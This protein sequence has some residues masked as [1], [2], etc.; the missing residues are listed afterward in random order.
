MEIKNCFESGLKELTLV[1]GKRGERLLE[2]IFWIFEWKNNVT[3]K[4]G[5][6]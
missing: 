5:I 6:E 1:I 3:L 4:D 2:G